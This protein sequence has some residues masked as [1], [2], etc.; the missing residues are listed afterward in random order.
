MHSLWRDFHRRQRQHKKIST[1][2]LRTVEKNSRQIWQLQFYIRG[3]HRTTP[4]IARRV[5]IP[6][7]A[8]LPRNDMDLRWCVAYLP[9]KLQTDTYAE[10][11]IATGRERP[12]VCRSPA[13]YRTHCPR[14]LPAKNLHSPFTDCGEIFSL[15]GRTQ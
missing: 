1:V 12:M 11:I 3:S 13:Q 4:I 2:F 7:V 9:A 15:S 14:A 8:M 5:E 6:T 10:R